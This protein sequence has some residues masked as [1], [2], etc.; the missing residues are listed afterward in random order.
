[1]LLV[2]WSEVE[3]K[4]ESGDTVFNSDKIDTILEYKRKMTF[5]EWIAKK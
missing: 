1:M 4:I 3:A 2:D 5:A